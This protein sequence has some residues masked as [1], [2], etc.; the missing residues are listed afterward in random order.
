MNLF[1]AQIKSKKNCVE[2]VVISRGKGKINL[3][4]GRRDPNL[5]QMSAGEFSR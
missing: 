5:E 1:F 2:I 3:P 4:T